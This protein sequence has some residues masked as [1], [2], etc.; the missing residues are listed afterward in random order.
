MSRAAPSMTT[1]DTPLTLQEWEA[2]SPQMAVL[3]PPTSITMTSPGP[4]RS[5]A[6]TGFAQ[7][8]SAV[9]TVRAR[10]TIFVPRFTRGRMP[11]ITP[12][13]CM[14]SA[15]LGVETF[16]RASRSSSSRYFL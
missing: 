11:R 16:A 2:S 6:S 4:A 13:F 3:P 14:A 10:P 8:P 7:S 15:R 12:R 9:F 5:M 1:P